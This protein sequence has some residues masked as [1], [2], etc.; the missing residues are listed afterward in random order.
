MKR[1]LYMRIAEPGVI[2]HIFSTLRVKSYTVCNVYAEKR[3]IWKRTI[4]P[5]VKDPPRLK[6]RQPLEARKLLIPNHRF[7]SV[8][9]NKQ[10]DLRR[11]LLKTQTSRLYNCNTR[12]A[13]HINIMPTLKLFHMSGAPFPITKVY[14]NQLPLTPKLRSPDLHCKWRWEWQW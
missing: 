7:S 13:N 2:S 5:W 9:L 3:R 4:A 11:Y 10:K 1:Q 6:W 8:S 12:G 14:R